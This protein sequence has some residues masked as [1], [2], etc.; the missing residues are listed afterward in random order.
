MFSTLVDNDC[1]LQFYELRKKDGITVI[2]EL[3]TICIYMYFTLYDS[4][5]EPWKF[6][7]HVSVLN[8]FFI[9]IQYERKKLLK[10]CLTS[11][12]LEIS[13]RETYGY[14]TSSLRMSRRK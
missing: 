2:I 7:I 8:A 14:L 3:I 1:C 10:H 5:I 12:E 9:N 6:N 11:L 13:R 4:P